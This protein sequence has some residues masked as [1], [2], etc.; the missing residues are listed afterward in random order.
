MQS[1]NMISRRLPAKELMDVLIRAGL[2]V[3]VVFMSVRVF[4]PFMGLM[5]WA[6]IFAVALYPLQQRLAK[7]LGGRQGGAAILLVMAAL[8]L[9]GGPTVMLGI[10]FAS[11]VRDVYITFANNTISIKQPSPSVAEWP[12]IGEHVHAAWSLAADDLPAFLEKIRPQL[13][14]LLDG[15]LVVAANT[16]GTVLLFLASLIISGVMMAYGESGSRAMGRIMIRISGP[17]KGPQLHSL[18]T[19]TIRSVAT[20]IIG[21]AFLQALLL[22]IGFILAGIP[23][24]GVLGIIVLLLGIVQLPAA[25]VSLPVIAYL[26]WAGDAST[27]SNIIFTAYLLAASLADNVLKPLLLGRGVGAPMPVVLLGALGGMLSAGLIG[28]F[29]G[30]VVL[31]VGYQ[32][33]M[34]WV[35]EPE[36]NTAEASGD[37]AVVREG[38]PARE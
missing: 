34:Q 7:R 9:I 21:V 19:A 28:L 4:A 14:N 26:W 22:G 24:A 36:E 32:I 12:L 10:S 2:I 3:L 17:A 35:D 23:A 37:A 11:H 18:S 15:L 29:V 38:S 13:K 33:F 30:A 1:D 25:I 8:L 5:L 27:T 31:T 16:A 20:G 6:L